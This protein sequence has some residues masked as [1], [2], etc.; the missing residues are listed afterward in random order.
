MSETKKTGNKILILAALVL[1]FFTRWAFYRLELAITL[2]AVVF[3]SEC[4]FFVVLYGMVV[5]GLRPIYMLLFLLLGSGGLSCLYVFSEGASKGDMFLPL[6]YFPVF[7]FLIDQN[8]LQSDKKNSSFE[9]IRNVV[10]HIYLWGLAALSIWYAFFD[11]DTERKFSVFSLVIFVFVGLLYCLIMQ[12]QPKSKK[13]T[14]VQSIK[15]MRFVFLFAVASMAETFV[16]LLLTGNTALIHTV[17]L[18]WLVNILLLYFKDHP[19]V[20]GFGE[21]FSNSMTGFLSEKKYK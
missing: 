16:F 19:L 4:V 6:T 21:R 14:K 10:M 3:V 15:R 13:R 20:G 9:T 2:N 8:C 18:M 11:R 5:F 17:P 1:L 7:F 12:V